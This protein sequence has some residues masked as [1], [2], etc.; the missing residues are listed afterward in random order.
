[1][2]QFFKPQRK[3]RQITKLTSQSVVGLDH[4]GRG[5]VRTATGTYFIAGALPGEQIDLR[6]EKPPNGTLVAR[7]NAAAE[8]VEPR[9]VHYQEC[10][11]CDLQHLAHVAQLEHKQ[12]VVAELLQK[13]AQTQPAHWAPPLTAGAWQTRHRTRLACWWDKRKNTF[14]LG[15]RARQAHTVV[16]VTECVVLAPELELLIAPLREQLGQL[17]LA[18]SLGHV[19]LMLAPEALLL[20]RLTSQLTD[21]DRNQLLDWQAQHSVTIWLHTVT[22]EVTPLQQEPAGLSPQ[23]LPWFSSAQH[24]VAFTPGDFMQAN[25]DLNQQMVTQAV[26]WLAANPTE[27]VLEL[28]AGSGNFSLAL[29]ETAAQLVAVE[30]SARMTAQIEQNAQAAGLT[31]ITAIAADLNSPWPPAL[32]ELLK[33]TPATKVLLDPARAGAYQA[34][35]QLLALPVLPERLVYVSCAP[36]TLARDAK[37]LIAAGYQLERCGIVDMFPQTHHI[38]TMALFIKV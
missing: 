3:P 11:G 27:T 8:R 28:F 6:L 19:E 9:C 18:R 13:F 16:D 38:E 30:G 21:S 7:Q 17:Q 29:S 22:D 20:L 31:N 36:D 35:T 12:Q 32:A 37:L 24:K 15:L 10:G 34:L 1:M 14:H 23:S 25:G 5:I 26:D 4:Q 33:Q 2:A